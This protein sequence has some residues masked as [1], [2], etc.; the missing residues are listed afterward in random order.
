MKK[1][2]LTMAV[3]GASL[4]AFAQGK[5]SLQN[6]SGSL[7]TLAGQSG[8]PASDSSG[9]VMYPL[10]ADNGVGGS[11]IAITGPLPSSIT[12]EIGLYG[13]SSAAVMTLQTHTLLNPAGGGAGPGPGQGPFTHV[14]T[15]IAPGTV[16]FFQVVIWDSAYASPLLAQAAGSYYGADNV[17]SMTTGASIAYPAI[18]SGGNT[19]WAAVG[20]EAP[21]IVG[22]SIPEPAT[23]ALA[24]LGAAAMVIFRRRK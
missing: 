19:T 3:A 11:P 18:N 16:G 20:D 22:V 23:F 2:L 17:F 4:A 13:G 7:Y 9:K 5:V 12:L 6:D 21:L 1:T 14:A 8:S 24:G 15:S 10:A